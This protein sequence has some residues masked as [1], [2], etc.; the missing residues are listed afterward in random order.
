M[1]TEFK[2]YTD[3]SKRDINNETLCVIAGVILGEK[4][5]PVLEFIIEEAYAGSEA[6]EMKALATG[7]E[8][9]YE[10]GVKK[11]SCFVDNLNTVKMLKKVQATGLEEETKLK[12]WNNKF[13]LFDSFIVEH[14]P[15]EFNTYANAMA[16]YPFN[17]RLKGNEPLAYHGINRSK[18]RFYARLKNGLTKDVHDFQAK[19]NASVYLKFKT[20]RELLEKLTIKPIMERN[21]RENKKIE[22][23]FKQFYTYFH[24]VLYSKKNMEELVNVQENPVAFLEFLHTTEINKKDW[25]NWLSQ[26]QQVNLH[27]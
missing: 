14:V 27:I 15:R 8:L 5:R 24:T 1:E 13:A 11:L 10:M 23:L 16:K 7:V 9:A 6:L 25:P 4:N 3:A 12:G 26:R 17:V 19:S 18:K 21:D 20:T 2:L 22:K